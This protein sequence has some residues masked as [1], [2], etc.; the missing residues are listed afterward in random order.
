MLKIISVKNMNAYLE[1]LNTLGEIV[2]LKN[3]PESS[4]LLHGAV[5]KITV[6]QKDKKIVN[7][8][9]KKDDLSQLPSD[10]FLQ[11]YVQCMD[12]P[13]NS[14][15]MTYKSFMSFLSVC[16]MP[17]REIGFYS[18]LPRGIEMY[19]PKIYK[20]FEVNNISYIVME[21][22]SYCRN[23]NAIL[24]PYLWKK[25][26][27]KNAISG[28]AKIHSI[29]FDLT[30]PTFEVSDYKLLMAFLSDFHHT[31]TYGCGIDP[32]SSVYQAGKSYIDMIE[33]IEMRCSCYKCSIH[34]D[35]NIRN[36]CIDDRIGCIKVYDWEFLAT[37][38][39]LIDI[40]D[41]LISLSTNYITK[42]YVDGLLHI[43]YESRIISSKNNIPFATFIFLFQDAIRKYC[44]IR[45]NLYLLCYRTRKL[46]Y[47]ERMYENLQS[48]I[49]LFDV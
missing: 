48:L 19:V 37:D 33:S 21:D 17:D 47:I 41:F 46:K 9:V 38:N 49:Y 8:V 12:R 29:L 26:D 20:I 28:L 36:V 43:Y 2:Q 7:L 1:Q 6:K 40:V 13:D 35:F 44:A 27:V 14:K 42:E 11:L 45:M 5:D 15:I 24:T 10:Q 18:S 23:L 39:P 3:A 4:G 32:L 31:I 25:D 30:K 16:N 34:N 22:L